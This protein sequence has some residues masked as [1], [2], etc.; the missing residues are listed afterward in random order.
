MVGVAPI[1]SAAAIG[2]EGRGKVME[3]G[4]HWGCT[5]WRARPV[6]ES[7]ERSTSA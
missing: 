7:R 5:D 1:L 3:A 2:F 4:T 6:P